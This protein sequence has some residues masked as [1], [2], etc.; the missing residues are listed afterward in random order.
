M[1]RILRLKNAKALLS[2]GALVDVPV[3]LTRSA[4][5][6]WVV[7]SVSSAP[8]NVWSNPQLTCQH[9]D[10]QSS[11]APG[12]RV[13]LEVKVSVMRAS[14]DQVLEHAIREHGSMR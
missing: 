9:V 7:A 5:G 1:P 3:I 6:E 8:G 10:P 4:D 14:P 11:L 2:I 12:Q 13:T